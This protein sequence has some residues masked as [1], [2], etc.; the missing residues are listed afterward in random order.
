MGVGMIITLQ[1]LLH[2]YISVGD[3]VTGQPLPLISQGGTSVIINC[4]YIGFILSVSRYAKKA[5]SN[6]K[7]SLEEIENESINE[8]NQHYEERV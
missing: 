1:A 5:N 8:I 6:P 3:F 7:K 2:M 4:V